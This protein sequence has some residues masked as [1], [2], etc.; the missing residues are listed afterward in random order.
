MGRHYGSATL[1]NDCTIKFEKSLLKL[2]PLFKKALDQLPEHERSQHTIDRPATRYKL[3][4]AFNNPALV[5]HIADNP[6]LATI[7]KKAPQQLKDQIIP[8]QERARTIDLQRAVGALHRHERPSK[9]PVTDDQVHDV[10]V[11][12]VKAHRFDVITGN[13]AIRQAVKEASTRKD[14]Q[15]F[16]TLVLKEH[17]KYIMAKG[18][19]PTMANP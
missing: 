3:L 11:K 14:A 6:L 8:L 16:N 2:E 7:F 12:L 15:E 5:R 9:T 13:Q 10:L 1:G 19:K 18:E 4:A 17:T